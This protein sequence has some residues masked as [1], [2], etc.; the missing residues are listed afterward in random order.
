M[1]VRAQL[2]TPYYKLKKEKHESKKSGK[3]AAPSKESMDTVSPPLV[4]PV[5]VSVLELVDGQV[6]LQSP[7]L[8]AAAEKK[9]N[10][11]K[12]PAT[13]PAKSSTDKLM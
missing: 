2:S 10:T 1:K 4:D 12:C 5:L 7:S 6:L 3:T 8:S 11:E 9:K 13:K